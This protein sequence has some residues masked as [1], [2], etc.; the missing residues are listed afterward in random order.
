MEPSNVAQRLADLEHDNNILRTL[1][2]DVQTENSRLSYEFEVLGK[3]CEKL[4]NKVNE[5][6]SRFSV[7]Q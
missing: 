1:I 4:I 7:V 3:K 5:F 6:V 2:C